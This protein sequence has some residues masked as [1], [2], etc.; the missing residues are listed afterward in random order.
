M[1]PIVKATSENIE[2]LLEL[3]GQGVGA[4]FSPENLVYTALGE[5]RASH[6]HLVRFE[7]GA[8][9]PIRFGYRKD[10]YQWSLLEAF[11]RTAQESVR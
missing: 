4:C 10:T 8:S 9:Y 6:L 2:T 3:C 5:E 1:K 11:I 7:N